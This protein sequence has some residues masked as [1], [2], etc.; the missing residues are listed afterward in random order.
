MGICGVINNDIVL[1]LF[2]MILKVFLSFNF[3][4]YIVVLIDMVFVF[5]FVLIFWL[6]FRV[7]G[8]NFVIGFVL[9][10]MMV[11]FVFLNV[12]VVVLGD[13]YFIKFFGFILVVGY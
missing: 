6:V 1:V 10:L 5:F 3:Y 12:W 7:F 11:N 8:G 9:G 2:G 4:I 13:V